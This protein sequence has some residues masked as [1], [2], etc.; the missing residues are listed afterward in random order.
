MANGHTVDTGRKGKCEYICHLTYIRLMIELQQ[1]GFEMSPLQ[2]LLQAMTCEVPE[3]RP[4]AS[5]A[6]DEFAAIEQDFS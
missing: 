3:D 1:R 6:L 2:E 4:T 5:Q